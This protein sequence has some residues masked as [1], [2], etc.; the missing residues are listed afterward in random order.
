[1][2]RSIDQAAALNAAKDDRCRRCGHRREA[3]VPIERMLPIAPCAT[4]DCTCWAFVEPTPAAKRRAAET[5]ILEP[6]A[7]TERQEPLSLTVD[8]PRSS[9]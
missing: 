6:S 7:H 2:T 5:V 8:D 9:E 4:G 3:H 1:M